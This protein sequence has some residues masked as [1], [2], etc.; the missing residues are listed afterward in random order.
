MKTYGVMILVIMV[1][2]ASALP[3]EDDDAS[4]L[5]EALAKRVSQ[6][7]KWLGINSKIFFQVLIIFDLFFKCR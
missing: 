2:M 3:N 6:K 7:K 1:M 5:Y 4:L